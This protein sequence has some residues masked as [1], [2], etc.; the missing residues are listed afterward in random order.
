MF[1]QT[2]LINAVFLFTI[3]SMKGRLKAQAFS[4]DQPF[5]SYQKEDFVTVCLLTSYQYIH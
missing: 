5:K 2:S 1:V 3:R 4:F